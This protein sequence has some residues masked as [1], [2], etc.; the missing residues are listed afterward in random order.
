MP[1][2]PQSPSTHRFFCSTLP[3]HPNTTD[4]PAHPEVS[5][6]LCPLDRQESH[7]ARNVLRLSVGTPIELFNGQGVL[8]Q[9]TIENYQSNHA[10]CRI[11]HLQHHPPITPSITLASAVPK[12]PRADAMVAQLSQLG[13]DKFIPL[14]A[15]HSVAIPSSAK[16]ERF[17][18]STIESAKQCRRLHLMQIDDL[19]PPID[20]CAQ[21][22]YDL[23][24]ITT[25]NAPAIPDLTQR[26]NACKNILVMVG[27]EGGFSPAE[28]N[29]F[30]H[31]HCL[32]WSIAPNILRIE[33][34][35]TTAAAVLRYLAPQI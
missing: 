1:H 7:H 14:I 26:I 24:L 2:T 25:P 21:L 8:A 15:D 27:P 28:L 20:A 31:A 13:V 12:G 30:A 23:K 35:A 3:N 11:T 5:D 22:D 6:T 16:L 9:A 17:A 33:T 19:H 32:N 18:K 34:A 29:A 10:L 4:T